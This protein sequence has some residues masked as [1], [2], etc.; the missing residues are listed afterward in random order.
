MNLIEVYNAHSKIIPQSSIVLDLAEEIL[1]YAPAGAN[2]AM[3]HT[4]GWDG[5]TRLMNRKG[6]FPTGLIPHLVTEFKRRKISYKFKDCRIKPEKKYEFKIDGFPPRSYQSACAEMS[7]ERTRGVFVMG[8]G[9][10]KSYTAALIAARRGLDTLIITPDTGLRT[11]LSEDFKKWFGSKII[12]TKI[13]DNCPI[14]VTNIQSIA[15]ADPKLFLRFNCLMVDEFHHAAAKTYRKIN[16]QC[17][18]AFYRY[19]FTGTFVRPSGDDMEM[20]GVLSNVIFKITTSELIRM[21]FLVKPYV[22]LYKYEIPKMRCRYVEAYNYI[23]KDVDLQQ[24]TA[25][26]ADKKIKEG[27]QVLLVVRRI[28]HGEELASMI[29]NAIFLDGKTKSEIREKAKKDFIDRKIPCIVATNIFGEGIDIP[30]I[31]VYI[32]ARFEKTEIWTKQGI[33][34][35]L[36]KTEGKKTAEVFDFFIEGHGALKSHSKARLAS[37]QSEE[38]FVVHT[39]NIDEIDRLL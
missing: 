10:G 21:G 31:D 16:K 23:I 8:T 30:S 5:R 14:I 11:Q 20:L 15:K 9:A 37:Y 6:E 12:G 35:A 39:K 13:T 4:K 2:F 32:N 29:P 24:R 28:E 1:S 27:K 3:Q 17:V 26:L 19:G 33:G 38:E 18:N 25:R 22:T 7:D 36:R 34:R